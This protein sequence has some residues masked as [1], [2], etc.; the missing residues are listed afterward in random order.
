M[1]SDTQKTERRRRRK[2][3]T[4]GR[5]KKKARAKNSTPK[6]PIHQEG[7]APAATRKP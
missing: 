5:A 3:A 7:A 1:V 4:T 2:A 6:F